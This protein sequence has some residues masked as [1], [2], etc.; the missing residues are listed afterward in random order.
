MRVSLGPFFFYYQWLL[1]GSEG[2]LTRQL[3]KKWLLW[4]MEA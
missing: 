4:A 3:K 2:G 1:I